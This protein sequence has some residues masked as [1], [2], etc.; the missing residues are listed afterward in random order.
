MVEDS[1]SS[2]CCDIGACFLSALI[3]IQKHEVIH[4]EFQ[5]FQA[6]KLGGHQDCEKFPISDS[7]SSL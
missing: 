3:F 7:V 5:V 6:D 2:N 4:A 1:L